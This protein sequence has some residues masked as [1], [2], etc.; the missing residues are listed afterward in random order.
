M[1]LAGNICTECIK[2]HIA[3]FFETLG[4]N[5]SLVIEA[6]LGLKYGNE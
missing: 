6:Q 5:L 3:N 4:N 1:L 2:D